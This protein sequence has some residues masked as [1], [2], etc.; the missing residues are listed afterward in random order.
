LYFRLISF[1]PN[2]ITVFPISNPIFQP[3]KLRPLEELPFQLQV[4]DPKVNSTLCGTRE[5]PLLTHW[6]EQHSGLKLQAVL[7]P[8]QLHCEGETFEEMYSTSGSRL[9]CSRTVFV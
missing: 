7:G 6:F 9:V 5:A 2:V 1:P 4:Y 3:R 8:W